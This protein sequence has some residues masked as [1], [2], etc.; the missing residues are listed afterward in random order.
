MPF[1]F[2]PLTF[3]SFNSGS[4]ASFVLA[5]SFSGILQARASSFC[6]AAQIVYYVGK[7][8]KHP[9]GIS[10]FHWTRFRHPSGRDVYSLSLQLFGN[11]CVWAMRS[12]HVHG[13][14]CARP[15]LCF[16]FAMVRIWPTYIAFLNSDLAF[17]NGSI[18]AGPSCRY[19]TYG[20]QF[21]SVFR[22]FYPNCFRSLYV[23][24]AYTS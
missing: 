6:F 2:P 15:S 5:S 17:R 19:C 11:I 4:R 1:N 9:L 3:L 13:L 23:C 18:R 10:A 7:C 14:V 8:P 24:A 22:L 20:P 16:H 21:S 12:I